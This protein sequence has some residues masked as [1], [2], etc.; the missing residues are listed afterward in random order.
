MQGIPPYRGKSIADFV[1]NDHN[2]TLTALLYDDDQRNAWKDQ[3]PTY[4]LEVKSTSRSQ[5]EVFHIS[6]PQVETV[7]GI[8]CFFHHLANDHCVG[9]AHDQARRRRYSKGGLRH[10]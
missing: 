4:Y 10:H 8:A 6:G 5:K 9:A 1:Y 3:W 2:G 7:S